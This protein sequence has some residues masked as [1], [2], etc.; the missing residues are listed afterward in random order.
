MDP[1]YDPA[2]I[3]AAAQE[4]WRRER[5]FHV[6]EEP[7]RPKFYCLS[8]FPYPSG[9]LHMGHVRN[10]TIGDVI[11]RYQ[12]M[13]GRNVLQPMG[14]DA[15]GLPAENAAIANGVPP[16]KWTWDNIAYMRRQLQSLGFALDWEREIATCDPRYYRWNQWLFLRL[17]ER[18]LVYK[19][20]GTVN[21]DP[22][23]QTVLANEQV[24][25]GRGWRTGAVVEK[26]E[27]PMYYM[28][29]T[30]YAEELLAALDS[31]PGWPERVRIMQANWIGRSEGVEIG[32]PYGAGAGTL[33]VFTTRADTLYGATYVAV[34]AEHPLAVRAAADN[35]ELAGFVERCRQGSVMEADLATLEKEGMDTGLQVIH[36][37]TGDRLP[38]WVANYVLMGYG[39]GAIMAVP[40]HDERDFEFARKYGLPIRQVISNA[41]EER[42]R[43]GDADVAGPENVRFDFEVTLWKP[44]YAEQEGEVTSFCVNSGPLDGLPHQAATDRIAALLEEKGLGRKRIQFRLRDWGISRQRY[45]GCPIPIIHCAVCGEVPVPD[46]QLPVV[47][48]DHLVPDGSGNPLSGDHAFLDCKCPGCGAAA[49]RETDTMDTFVDSS[50]YFLRYPCADQSRAMVDERTQYWLP[51]D[52]YIGGIEHAILHLLYARFW[53]KAMRDLGLIGIDEPFSNLLTQGMVLNEIFLRRGEDGRITYFNPA[54]VDLETDARG[55]RTAARL[56]ADRLPVESDGMGTMSKSK[57]NGVDPQALVDRYG[58]DTARLFIMFASPPE[59][60]LEWSD[61]GVEGAYR[62]LKRLWRLAADHLAAGAAGA[63]NAAALTQAQRDLRRKIHETIAKV[64][65]DIGRRCTF[66]T[67]IAAVMELTNALSRADDPTPAGRALMREGI[68]MSVLLLSPIVPHITDAIWRELGHTGSLMDARWPVAEPGALTRSTVD[69][70]VQ[71]NGKLRGHVAVAPGAAQEDIRAAALGNAD[72]RRFT[73]G[74]EIRKVIIVPGRLINIVVA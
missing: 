67:A 59:Q 62:F 26:R 40:A 31:L 65:D 20:T 72:V 45:W 14:W 36:P 64:D 70:V 60:T 32:F 69:L 5:A 43:R 17:L 74:R 18:G 46:E 73:D 28:R 19:K 58:A 37:L 24:I 2:V 16:A 44:W 66:N 30:A 61:A 34:A 3:E 6:V 10:Y 41:I 22:V 63:V 49:R 52:Q 68:E 27:I 9:K 38:V 57:N 51:V 13:R 71:V 53:T 11:T 25:E 8:M 1:R 23:D 39:E 4:R 35:A 12:R 50:W 42:R 21:W 33:N 47:L 56:R 48:P 7:E 54:D 55:Q 29:I 15:F